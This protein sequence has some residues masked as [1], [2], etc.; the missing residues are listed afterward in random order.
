MTTHGTERVLGHR[1]R[2]TERIAAGG[3]GEVWQAEDTVLGRTVAVKLLRREYADDATFLA[4]FRNEARHTAG[5]SHPGIAAVYDFGEGGADVDE[6]PYLVM[7]HVPGEPLSTLVSREGTLSPERTLDIVGQAALGLQAAHD[8]GVIHR[9]VKPGNILV[10]PDGV[11]KVTDFGIARAANAVP[12]TQTGAIMGTAY[13]ISPEQASGRPVTPASDVYSLGVV[14][15]E[16]LT[17]RRPFDGD[18]P[19]SVALAQVSQEPPALPGDLPEPVRGLVMRMLAKD[20]VARPASA[21][22]LGQQALAMRAAA[23]TGRPA[24]GPTRTLL[25]V[26]G[27]DE[28]AEGPTTDPPHDG[29]TTVV[30]RRLDTDTDPGFRLPDPSSLPR[31]LPYAVGLVVAALVL[32]LVAR[33]CSADPTGTSTRQ[34]GTSS[35]AGGSTVPSTVDVVAKDF[36]GR[37]ESDV[38]A[39]LSGLGLTVVVAS[40][41]GGGVVGTVKDVSPTGTL[42]AGGR[43]TIAVVAAPAAQPKAPGKSDKPGKGNGKGKKKGR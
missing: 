16:C 30:A 35:S 29:G 20:P 12:L 33:A 22:E 8:A 39:D 38:Q 17:G 5:L 37:Q 18:T 21:G 23:A 32:L 41:A 2:L 31:W 14:A 9:D 26:G 10:T 6:S 7:E 15:Y 3:M 34:P 4:R 28:P 13:Y 42:D 24:P 40:S 43:V 11:V 25:P 1:Y 36:L 27:A 19:V